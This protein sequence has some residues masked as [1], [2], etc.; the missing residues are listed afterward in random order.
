MTEGVGMRLES[1]VVP[2]MAVMVTLTL[3]LSV[4]FRPAFL[5]TCR[6]RTTGTLLER[7]FCG[8]FLC[9]CVCQ[10]ERRECVHYLEYITMIFIYNSHIKFAKQLSIR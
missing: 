3:K 1:R 2:F 10:S 7:A 6:R 5:R 4:F 8:V 9:V